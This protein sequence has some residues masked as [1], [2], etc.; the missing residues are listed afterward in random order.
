VATVVQ[1]L[2]DLYRDRFE[3]APYPVLFKPSHGLR[4]LRNEPGSGF[5]PKAAYIFR[6]QLEE[7]DAIVINRM[8]ELT[9]EVVLELSRLVGRD[10]AGVPVLPISA[11]TG[12]GFD[13]LIQLLEQQ[14][15][16]GRK[17]LDID[18]DIYAEGEAELG[19]LNADVKVT[20]AKPFDLDAMLLAISSDLRQVLERLGAEV[21]HLK[22][23]G[24][25]SGSFGVANLVS[26][27]S[28][29]EL[30]LPSRGRVTEAELIVNARV[31]LDPAV[32]EQ[33]VRK[34][35]TKVCA[36]QKAQ[37]DFHSVQSFRPG[38]PQ[39]THRYA[40]AK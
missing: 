33:E 8:D 14:G 4:I 28:E 17:I 11:K 36:E 10:F 21:A 19:W 15:N 26:S 5:S 38:R 1:P 6:K 9:P 34:S 29:P 35:V 7:A 32:L 30:S 25:H 31:A 16:F 2:R 23:I 27:D 39:P 13:A 12:L 3:V 18:Y 40:M 22:T 20:A 37:A 24:I